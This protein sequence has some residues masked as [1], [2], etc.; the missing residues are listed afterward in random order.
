MATC[1]SVELWGRASIFGAGI[2][3]QDKSDAL[4]NQEDW[5]GLSKQI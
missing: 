1:T 3:I 5:D 2:L 4:K